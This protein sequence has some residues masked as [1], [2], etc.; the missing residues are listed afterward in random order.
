MTAPA[1]P[2][3][4]VLYV[5]AQIL[6]VDKPTGLLSVPGIGPDKADCL[7]ARL[8]S[9]Y[10]GCRI[11]H[12]LDRDTSGVIVLARSAA[13]HRDLSVQFQDRRVEKHYL[14]WVAGVPA[15]D[16]ITVDQPLRKDLD[17]PPRQM[18]D[19]RHGRPSRT[20]I[21]VRRREPDRALLELRPETGRSHQLRVHCAFVGH[22]I[23]GDDLYAPPDVIAAAP[24]LMLHAWRLRIHHPADRRP[25]LLEA[26]PPF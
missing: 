22:P 5:D 25:R 20:A 12:R 21:T 8:Q 2:P 18:I 9:A 23:L 10:P 3:I 13:S 1:D 4:P 6:A 7:V 17:R 11:V 15:F 24:R 16:E 14:A 19:P 26:R